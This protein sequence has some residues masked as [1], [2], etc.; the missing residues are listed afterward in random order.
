MPQ[1]GKAFAELSRLG[2]EARLSADALL[3]REGDPGDD[4]VLLLEGALE[5][6]R[7]SPEGEPVVVRTLGAGAILGEIAATD[8][9]VRSAAV[10]ASMP[11]R[12][13]RVPGDAF[14]RLVRERPDVLEE[15]FWQQLAWVR[16]LTEEVART[17][18]PAILDRQT[19]LYNGRFFRER[20]RGELD[21]ARE[22]GDLITIVL[23]DID[24]YERFR[25]REG[26]H[27][28]EGLSRVARALQGAARRG[29][30]LARLVDAR[31]AALLYGATRDDALR[32]AERLRERAE[33]TP[34][35]DS[36]AL[37][38]GRLTLLV[39]SATCPMDGT[40]ADALLDAAD[41]DLQRDGE[42]R[43]EGR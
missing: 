37:P 13:L 40:R 25:A 35:K 11:C 12:L 42:R 19:R 16:S 22:T 41:T 30:L 3:W 33:A 2:A 15:L 18:R 8:G 6:V 21:R 10:R 17:P 36:S 24:A 43:Q 32:F 5:V 9:L 23:L 39:G 7:E 31:F 20:L 29:D 26:G 1:G 28:G 38:G 34:L 14:R 27:D 4:V